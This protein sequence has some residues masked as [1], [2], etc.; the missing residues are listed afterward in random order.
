MNKCNKQC[1]NYSENTAT[2]K[3]VESRSHAELEALM[4]A[5]PEKLANFLLKHDCNGDFFSMYKKSISS[6][7]F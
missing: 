1:E 3:L 4:N 7:S 5:P 6:N 2:C